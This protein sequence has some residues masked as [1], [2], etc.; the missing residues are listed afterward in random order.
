M[1]LAFDPSRARAA[2]V[3]PI[4]ALVGTATLVI[5]LMAGSA[6]TQTPA[7][8]AA[9][10][11][12][13]DLSLE[14]AP[15]ITDREIPNSQSAAHVPATHVPR[16]ESKQVVST[17]PGFRGFLGLTHRD[18]RLADGGN[19]FSVEP[20]DQGLCV[21]AG[22]VIDTI[23][24]VF[25]VLRR[26]HRGEAEPRKRRNVVDCLLHRTAP[27]HSDAADSFRTVP[28]RSEVL[29]RS[30]AEP[31]LHDGRRARPKSGNRRV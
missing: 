18:Q 17:N 8:S 24:M 25:A 19:Q 11:T 12:P 5:A 28:E 16:P 4:G 31:V 21:G 26:H 29:L 13:I 10:G 15:Q 1:N 3:A 20:P 9:D 23:N 14:I 7:A 2:R 22:R 30:G 27:D 6:W